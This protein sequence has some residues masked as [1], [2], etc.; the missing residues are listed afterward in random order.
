MKKIMSVEQFEMFEQEQLF[1]ECML[2]LCHAN[3]T[4]NEKSCD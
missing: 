1:C 3:N 4:H 2:S